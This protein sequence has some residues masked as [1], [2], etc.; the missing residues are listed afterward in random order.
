[1]N[2]DRVR[3]P[4]ASEIRALYLLAMALFVVTVSIG[5][6]NGLDL[7][8]FDRQ[9]IL[10]HVHSGTLGWITMSVFATTFWM[11]GEGREPGRVVRWLAWAAGIF[12]PFYILAFFLA[13]APL[14]AATGSVVL[15]VIL[16]VLGWTVGASRGRPM[17]VPRLS[18]LAG[19]TTLFVGAVFGVLQQVQYATEQSLTSGNVIG[20]HAAAMAFSYLVLAAMGIIEWRL[21]PGDRLSRSG[22]VQVILLFL[23]GLVLSLG[24]FANAD[25]MAIGGIYLLAEVVAVLIFIARMSRPVLGVGWGRASPERHIGLAG[26]F[27][28][29]DIGILMYLIVSIIIGAKPGETPDVTSIPVWLIFALDHA[30]FI[31]VMTNLAFGLIRTWADPIDHRWPWPDQVTI[32]GMN[33]GMIGFIVGLALESAE[34]K[35]VFSPIMGISILI[36]LLTFGLRLWAARASARSSP[37]EG[38][39]A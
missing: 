36:G 8:E 4:Y 29:V 30:I 10:T 13:N 11:F 31:G 32:W 5:I 1:M 22:T 39:S 20:A 7:V 6:T 38:A 34:I 33:I 12:I 19:L 23:S 2:D 16:G 15:L 25:L 14:R 27:V 9:T 37:A 35:R 21:R 17:T 18:L 26:I 28:V 24:T 3:T